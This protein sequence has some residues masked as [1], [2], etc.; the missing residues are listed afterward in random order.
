[1]ELPPISPDQAISNLQKIEHIVVLMMEN[2]SFDHMLGYLSLEKGR[3]DIDGLK[4]GMSNTWNGK[5]YAIHRM[6]NPRFPV[7]EDPCHEA[8]CVQEHLSENNGGFVKCF[9]ESFPNTADPGL[10]MGYYFADAL[11]VYDQFASE[12]L[13]CDRWFAPVAG[14]TWPN[15]LYALAGTS[16]GI[17]TTKRSVTS[18]CL[19]MI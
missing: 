11:P 17:K 5:D 7:K 9:G 8:R 4:R 10:V 15:R 2:R 16:G 19:S 1:M 12:F 14:Q 3:D 6:A 13:I 18:K